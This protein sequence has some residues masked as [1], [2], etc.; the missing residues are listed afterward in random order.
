MKLSKS[1]IESCCREGKLEE[2]L[3]KTKPSKRQIADVNSFHQIWK[4]RRQ[5][6]IMYSNHDATRRSEK[7]L[8]F[9]EKHKTAG[10]YY[11]LWRTENLQA[12]VTHDFKY[13]VVL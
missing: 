11:L 10:L 2:C 7:I 4:E 1:I 13:I 9:I 8:A 12:I 6:A 3:R 5:T